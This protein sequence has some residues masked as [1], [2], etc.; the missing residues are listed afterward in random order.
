MI[1]VLISAVG[2]LSFITILRQEERDLQSQ[3]SEVQYFIQDDDSE[4]DSKYETEIPMS[5]SAILIKIIW[6]ILSVFLT[7]CITL[8]LFPSITSSVLPNHNQTNLFITVHFLLYN[9]AD[10]IGKSIPGLFPFTT[11][12]S[13]STLH[14]LS[15][16]RLLFLPIFFHCNVNLFNS[17]H[18]K[19][20][21][22]TVWFGD[23]SFFLL[24]IL[25][26]LSNGFIGTLLLMDAPLLLKET[27]WHN[28][29]EAQRFVGDC[30][31]FG[32]GCGLTVGALSSFALRSYLCQCNP[33]T[34]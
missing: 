29:L 26:A 17:D 32:L 19:I 14:F 25:F 21:N 33:F 27:P 2:L 31:V 22:P 20:Y 9:L 6:H 12:I 23:T 4:E 8:A 18:H 13:R 28:S 5:R 3:N 10:W 15:L 16:S 7:F 1:S 30:M 34:Y 24:L 11:K